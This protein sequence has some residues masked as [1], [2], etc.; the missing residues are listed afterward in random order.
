MPSSPQEQ[1]VTDLSTDPPIPEDDEQDSGSRSPWTMLVTMLL[2]ISGLLLTS[3][4]M[5]DSALNRGGEDSGKVIDFSGIKGKSTD[6]K[7]FFKKQLEKPEEETA[8]P[9]TPEAKAA[10]KEIANPPGP[11]PPSE[12]PP[13]GLNRFFS[14]R[15]GSVRWPK[16]KLT[17]FGTSSDGTSNFAIINGDQVQV[18]QIIDGKVKVLEIGYQNV[19]VEYMGET[20]ILTVS[21]KD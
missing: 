19:V 5:L 4:L 10:D 16:L 13:S 18:G 21:V 1:A 17:G 7:A 6:L 3:A 14:G 9:Q 2:L 20:N 11:V 12:K 15:S 8:A